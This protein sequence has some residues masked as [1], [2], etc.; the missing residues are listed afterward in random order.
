MKKTL[1]L[2]LALV[3][4]VTCFTFSGC[5]KKAKGYNYNLDDYITLPDYKNVK[6]D[7]E[8]LD[9]KMGVS[10][11]NY[12]NFANLNDDTLITETELTKGE[13]EVLDKAIIDYS[14]KKDG[15]KFEGGTASDQELQIGS[16]SFIAGFESGLVGV[17]IGDT[18]DLNLTFPENY[19]SEEL[20]GADVIFTVTVKKVI[21]PKLAELTPDVLKKLGFSSKE[22]YE[23][24]LKTTYLDGFVWG[25]LV[26][27]AKVKKYPEA[28][29]K[30]Y[31]DAN[32]EQTRLQAQANGTTL[33]ALLAQYSM[34][35][36]SYREQLKPY[37]Q[38]N[39][40]QMM[41]AY[42]IARK[43]NIEVED[44]EVDEYVKEQNLSDSDWQNAK[45]NLV[46]NEVKEFVISNVK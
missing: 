1:S 27:N 5:G 40:T 36:E 35:E 44:A 10:Y 34:T 13:V 6:V 26:N 11:Q 28:E 15:V 39:V 37:A 45:D 16:S 18:V 33:E 41:L 46:L 29:M 19:G 24:N 17:K 31:I 43:E 30:A 20:A 9:Y 12:S 21:R 7:T 23:K 22:E 14:G 38:S 42:A 4:I 32:I 3:L 25:D 8:S 2:I